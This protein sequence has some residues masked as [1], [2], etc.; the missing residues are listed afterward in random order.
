MRTNLDLLIV[1][2]NHGQPRSDRVYQISH[3]LPSQQGIWIGQA[4]ISQNLIMVCM[5]IMR[6]SQQSSVE[7][8]NRCM[9]GCDSL[10]ICDEPT[11]GAIQ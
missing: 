9:K 2:P 8:E 1:Y 4:H 3:T 5:F 7:A 6:N 11:L 10:V